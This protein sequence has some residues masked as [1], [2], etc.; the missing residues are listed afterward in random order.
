MRRIPVI[1]LWQPWASWI[2]E[3]RKTI[4]TRDHNRLRSLVGRRILIHAGATWDPAVSVLAARYLKPR[5]QIVEDSFPRG[6]LLCLATVWQFRPL[7]ASDSRA[8]MIRVGHP[9]V[10][11]WGLFLSEIQQLSRPIPAKGSRGIWYVDET[12]LPESDRRYL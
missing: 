3:G 6:A 4:E 5:E 12:D 10:P 8:A 7:T 1:T 9:Q 11:R 2:A